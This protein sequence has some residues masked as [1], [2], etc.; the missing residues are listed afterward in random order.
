[1]LTIQIKIYYE[2]IKWAYIVWAFLTH[3]WITFADSLLHASSVSSFCSHCD[4]DP[5]GNI[6][7]EGI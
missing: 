4:D 2:D 6:I 5:S 1:M 7:Q 3:S